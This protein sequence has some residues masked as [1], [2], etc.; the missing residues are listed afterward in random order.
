MRLE[1]VTRVIRAAALTTIPHAPDVVLGILD[2]Q[3]EVIPVINL[4]RRFGLP[5]RSIGCEDQF[6]VART[7]KFTLALHVDT[8]EGVCD[9]SAGE[10]VA[11]DEI[12]AG[13]QFL[14]GVT[15]T[16]EGLVLIH[17]LDTLLFP[18]EQAQIQAAL[19]QV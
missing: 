19:E 5:E 3:G 9:Q 6:V 18:D 17:D 10:P 1:Q 16:A 15:R 2:L 7:G 14:A 12:V 11:A 13:T 4:R 8:A